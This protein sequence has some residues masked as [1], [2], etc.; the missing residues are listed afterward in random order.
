MFTCIECPDPEPLTFEENL[1]LIR[2]L[3]LDRLIRRLVALQL[4][5]AGRLV[6]DEA[7]VTLEHEHRP[8]DEVEVVACVLLGVRVAVGVEVP[9]LLRPHE[10]AVVP[11]ERDG[12]VLVPD[13]LEER[14]RRP[15]ICPTNHVIKLRS[16]RPPRRHVKNSRS[17][18]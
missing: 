18:K 14:V 12:P 11:P 10:L 17:N 8:V 2:P 13:E 7:L 3:D 4:R 9:R 1:P 5:R 16:A 15:E 6:P